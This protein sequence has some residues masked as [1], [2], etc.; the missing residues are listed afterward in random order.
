[1]CVRSC[2]CVCMCVCACVCVRESERHDGCMVQCVSPL[3]QF[4]LWN[5]HSD[6]TLAGYNYNPPHKELI[7][8]NYLLHAFQG[9]S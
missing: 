8:V 3:N 4:P 7:Y 1:M 5:D 9:R 2:V 6:Q